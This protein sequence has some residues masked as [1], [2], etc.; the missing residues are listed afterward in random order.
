MCVCVCVRVCVCVCGVGWGGVGG[1]LGQRLGGQVEAVAHLW[2]GSA[3]S[4]Q[5]SPKRQSTHTLYKKYNKHNKY[6]I[7][8]TFQIG[9]NIWI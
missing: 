1:G 2:G 8:A 3:F 5:E 6:N 9:A 7:A 4:N